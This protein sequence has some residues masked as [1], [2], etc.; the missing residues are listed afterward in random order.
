MAD[1]PVVQVTWDGAS[2]YCRHL[3]KRLPTEAEWE[4]AARGTERRRFPWGDEPPRC[5]GVAFGREEPVRCPG[6]P[7][8]VEPVGASTQ[9]VTPTGL[10]DLGG[11][12]GEWVQD[13]F[14]VPY[15]ACGSCRD[16][17]V[18]DAVLLAD[19]VRVFRG[20]TFLGDAWMTRTTNRSRSSRTS[21]MAGLGFR[22]ATR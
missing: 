1:R 16:P 8:T 11:N 15:R 14:V 2:R 6:P 7:L 20:G 22:C 5:D 9:D 4:L 13:A 19:D 10:R 12:A 3:G 17:V 21:S 18:E